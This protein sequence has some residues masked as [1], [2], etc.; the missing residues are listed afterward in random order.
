MENMIKSNKKS[1]ND[2]FAFAQN[3]AKYRVLNI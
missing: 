3:L 1:N 2:A